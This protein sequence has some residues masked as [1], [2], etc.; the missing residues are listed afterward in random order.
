MI[1]MLD[2]D[3]GF[4]TGKL[5]LEYSDSLVKSTT[6]ESW[7]PVYARSFRRVWKPALLHCHCRAGLNPAILTWIVE[8]PE[9]L[10]ILL[11]QPH[12]AA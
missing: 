11:H 7:F 6:R 1:T 9:Q 4:P 2:T 8:Q 3:N 12:T 5:H 10:K